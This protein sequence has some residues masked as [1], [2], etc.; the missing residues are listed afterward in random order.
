MDIKSPQPVPPDADPEDSAPWDVRVLRLMDPGVDATS[1]AENLKQTPTERLR[2][3]Q[4]M[5]GFL[6][7]AQRDRHRS[8]R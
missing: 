6:K 7:T 3:M 1:I 5:V 8:P 4:Q 2:R